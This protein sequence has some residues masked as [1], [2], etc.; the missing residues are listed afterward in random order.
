MAQQASV[1]SKFNLVL[2]YL[3]PVR[4]KKM[5]NHAESKVIFRIL[6]IFICIW[7][8]KCSCI[9]SNQKIKWVSDSADNKFVI[10]PDSSEK[11][12]KKGCFQIIKGLFESNLTGIVVKLVYILI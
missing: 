1:S 6:Y 5:V 7:K 8:Y 9:T 11:I 4:E 3:Y 12:F 2:C 10:S